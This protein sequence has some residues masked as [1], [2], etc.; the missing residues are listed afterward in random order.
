MQ[1]NRNFGEGPENLRRKDILQAAAREQIAAV[2]REKAQKTKEAVSLRDK[3]LL[4]AEKDV[5]GGIPRGYDKDINIA[6]INYEA[7]TKIKKIEAR[8]KKAI[9]GVER[10]LALKIEEIDRPSNRE[11]AKRLDDETADTEIT[12]ELNE[13][14]KR[15]RLS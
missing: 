5:Q 1:E 7:D 14:G 2:N 6:R 3:L 13:F 10:E 12:K 8:A 15:N 11:D 9:E 4:D